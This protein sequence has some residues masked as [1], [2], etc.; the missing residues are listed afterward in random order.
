MTRISIAFLG[1]LAVAAPAFAQDP[2]VTVE[3]LM[4]QGFTIA[5]AITSPAGPGLFLQNK[6]KA[7]FCLVVETPRSPSVGTRYCKPV[8]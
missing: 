7:F 4:K 3:S 6:E 5:A 1:A 2:A 8:Q